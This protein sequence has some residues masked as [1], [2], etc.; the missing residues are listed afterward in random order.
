MTSFEE[1]LELLRSTLSDEQDITTI[2]D[3]YVQ[4]DQI[5]PYSPD[6][7]AQEYRELVKRAKTNIIRLPP[8]VV[9]QVS[10]IA[11]FRR[12]EDYED[13]GTPVSKPF[14]QEWKDLKRCRLGVIES[15]IYTAA[16]TYGQAFVEV[17][18]GP[19][20]EPKLN[21]LSSLNTTALFANPVSDEF[22]TLVYSLEREPADDV[23]GQA[24]GW[25]E[26]AKY[27]IRTDM[28]GEWYVAETYPH[29]LGVTPVVRFHCFLDTEGRASGL[30]EH[31]IEPQDR[32][33]QSVLDLLTAQAYTG[34]PVRTASGVTGEGVVDADGNPVI[35]PYT[36]KQATKPIRMDGRRLLTAESPDARFSTLAGADLRSLLEAIGDALN[37]FA[38]E[39]QM[40]PYIFHQGGFDNLS[41]DALAAID[42]QFFRLINMLHDQWAESWCSIMRLFS[43]VRGDDAGA[44]AFDSEV[45]WADYSIKT[46][47]GIADGLAKVVD[48]LEIPKRGAW[49]LIPGVSASVLQQW[50][51]LK[52]K[53]GENGLE[54]DDPSGFESEL[55]QTR[56]P[57]SIE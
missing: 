48:S 40:S 24:W 42:A 33:N 18:R 38:I 29:G 52:E 25:D 14:P 50:D 46:F 10:S 26:V 7:Y 28:H 15:P 5:N 17:S 13:D 31:L 3:D 27:D 51:E 56:R 54:P 16:A 39:G 34:Q 8:V 41:T 47:A 19:S 35:D 45:R 11:G 49:Q 4:G 20:G 23:V 57:V 36:G 30:V 12:V 9:A 22:P 55:N 2:C 21:V 32:I 37:T 43:K 6:M 1:N 53:E 44:S